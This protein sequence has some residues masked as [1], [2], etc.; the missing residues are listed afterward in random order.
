[1]KYLLIFLLI[2][3]ELY[4]YAQSDS[5]LAVHHLNRADSLRSIDLN[6]SVEE[7]AKAAKLSSGISINLHLRS[8]IYQADA[9]RLA[10]NFN[11]ALGIIKK[12]GKIIEEAEN[13]DI[14]AHILVSSRT[15]YAV[16]LQNLGKYDKATNLFDS[17]LSIHKS[18]LNNKDELLTSIYNMRGALFFERDYLDKAEESFLNALDINLEINAPEQRIGINYNNLAHVSLARE[19]LFK[20]LTYAQKSLEFKLLVNAPSAPSNAFSH[21]TLGEVYNRLKDHDKALFHQNQALTIRI[22]N[23]GKNNTYVSEMYYAIG[24]TYGNYLDY[25]SGLYY[26]NKALQLYNISGVVP[27]RLADTYYSYAN[28]L[29]RKGKDRQES[30]YFDT[31]NIYLDSALSI[32]EQPSNPY[33]RSLIYRLKSRNELQKK[34]YKSAI[35][36]VNEGIFAIC[37]SYSNSDQNNPMFGE[38]FV[39]YEQEMIE[40]LYH[41]FRILTEKS[42]KNSKEEAWETFVS[43]DGFIDHFLFKIYETRSKAFAQESIGTIYHSVIDYFLKIGEQKIALDVLQNFK[44]KELKYI[45]SLPLESIGSSRLESL[46]AQEK[47]MASKLNSLK[48]QWIQSK[49]EDVTQRATVN[50]SILLLERKHFKLLKEIDSKVSPNTQLITDFNLERIPK[51]TLVL[52]YL[53]STDSLYVFILA[54]GEITVSSIKNNSSKKLEYLKTANKKSYTEI[55][56][57]LLTFLDQG[58]YEHISRLIIIPDGQVWNVNFDLLLTEE[59][60]SEDPRQLPYLFKKY[61]ISYAYSASLLFQK[62]NAKN[63]ANRS[64]LAFSFGDE[65]DSE[66]G[67]QVALRTLRASDEDLPGSRREVKAISELI[68]GDYYFG[69]YASEKQFKETAGDY[70]VLH[71]AI[72]GEVDDQESENSKLNFYAEGDSLEDGQLHVFEIYNMELNADL[73]VLSACETGTGEIVRGEGVMSLGRAFAYAGVNSLLLT[74]WEV[75]DAYTPEIMA[76][77]YQEL[78]K[79][80]RKSEALRQAKLEF[81][82][83]ADII[84]A[85]PFYWSSFYVLGDDSPIEFKDGNNYWLYALALVSLTMLFF[86]LRNRHH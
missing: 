68:D 55:Y 1:M 22:Q 17:A 41:K 28:I 52:E 78:K 63:N 9:L 47:N 74:R 43:L 3:C 81:L 61:A 32:I 48:S 5:L 12:A 8:L 67:Q 20:A 77:F 26:L 25:D 83:T 42:T 6:L 36:F 11:D 24:S 56:N 85:D 10:G 13:D 45:T 29:N 46:R 65:D 86:L 14:D 53:E 76:T 37:P 54:K 70:Q 2:N 18:H 60:Q 51:S 79:G 80:K 40:L 4:S 69:R 31:S 73:A 72:H 15:T 64:L 33:L 75:S 44:A 71:L 34:N 21:I 38:H 82:E 7:Y 66:S 49:D 30:S 84:T 19:D 50:D 59:P 58:K 39:L 35:Q 23:F 57:T 16:I 27:T 62:E